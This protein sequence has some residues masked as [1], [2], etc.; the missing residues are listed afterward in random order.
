MPTA[1]PGAA[2][3][4][5][6][7]GAG[8]GNTLVDSFGRQHTYLRI[9]VTDR[10]NLRCVYCL[11]AEGFT[12]TDRTEILQFGE[13]IR[14]AKIFAGMGINK[15]RLTG[16]E[17]LV[18]RGLDQLI[19]GLAEI[20]RIKTIALTTNGV[21]L[22]EQAATL[23]KAG[24]TRL[25]VSLDTLR[26]ERFAQIAL[27]DLFQKISTGIDTALAVGFTPLKINVVLLGGLNDDEL[28]DFVELTRLRPLKVRFIE[29]M[30]FGFA[31]APPARMISAAEMSR[32]IQQHYELTPTTPL[33]GKGEGEG[34]A[35][36]ARDFH[37]PG[38]QGTIGF[39]SPMSDHFCES[40]NRLRLT[41]DGSLKSCL[42]FPAETNLRDALRSGADDEELTAIIHQ[43]LKKKQAAHP[44]AEELADAENNAMIKIGG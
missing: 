19:S 44:P 26:P 29:Y 4:N 2:R 42:F 8:P 11:P 6:V 12:P 33:E 27:R 18:R 5:S 1:A 13:I 41:A 40:C 38:F 21:L 32:T 25:N 15:I 34:E 28:L 24:L 20:D 39:I 37:I 31:S 3:E 30:P 7:D 17:P 16:G 43:V 10:C 14:L 9:S 22:A 35:Q 36:V 23:K